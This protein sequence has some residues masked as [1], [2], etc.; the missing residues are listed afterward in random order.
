MQFE[1]HPARPG[2][3]VG[4][5][6]EDVG[7]PPPEPAVEGMLCLFG[8]APGDWQHRVYLIPQRTGIGEIVEFFEVGSRGAVAHGWDEYETMDVV[9]ETLL[10]VDAV[11]PGSVE[12]ADAGCLRFRFWRRITDQELEQIEDCYR[13]VDVLQAGLEGYVDGRSGDSLLAEVQVTGHLKLWWA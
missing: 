10:T 2:W 1:D 11:V 3:K 4:E 12:L 5:E 7:I 6:V 8:M 13:R 9:S